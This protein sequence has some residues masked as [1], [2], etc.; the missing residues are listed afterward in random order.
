[1]AT[2]Q[3]KGPKGNPIIEEQKR[4]ASEEKAK[5]EAAVP[6]DGKPDS[7]EGEEGTTEVKGF[8]PPPPKPDLKTNIPS[9]ILKQEASKRDIRTRPDPSISE[10]FTAGDTALSG[11][12]VLV[13]WKQR[14]FE[15]PSDLDE[16]S[17]RSVSVPLKGRGPLK[18]LT[19]DEEERWMPDLIGMSSTD[20]GFRKA[21]HNFYAE[22]SLQIPYQ[23]AK[24]N[25]ATD[26][27]GNPENLEDYVKY[28]MCLVNPTV[29]E[30][31]EM[32]DEVANAMFYIE[33]PQANKLRRRKHAQLVTEAQGVLLRIIGED[34]ANIKL[35]AILER[36]YDDKITH[37]HPDDYATEIQDV[38]A[39]DPKKFIAAAKDPNILIAGLVSRMLKYRVL[40]VHGDSYFD[41]RE[42]N[43]GRNFESVVTF[44]NDPSNREHIETLKAQLR[45][46][47]K[48]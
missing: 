3:A 7:E 20:P 37:L 31:Y 48:V 12:F 25:I 21:V 17:F 43:I 36:V 26:N 23:G 10:M 32:A 24:L 41:N 27:R 4:K 42:R 15:R 8:I 11:E 40:E 45:E 34:D 29:A 22:L 18:I 5:A 13:K 44:F 35:A 16:M 46:K 39:S 19:N 38:I 30:S 47:M 6:K 28:R 33:D 14:N 1:M 2:E 9:H